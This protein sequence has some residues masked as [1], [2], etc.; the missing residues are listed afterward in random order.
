[1]KFKKFKL[2]TTL[3]GLYGKDNYHSHI[4]VGKEYWYWFGEETKVWSVTHKHWNKIVVTYIRSGCM[5]YKVPDVPEIS[6][7]YC[8]LSC[9]MTSQFEVTELDPIKE[10]LFDD[11]EK[12]KKLYYFKGY[13]TVIHNW[14]N[15]KEIEIS[16]DGELYTASSALS[17]WNQMSEEE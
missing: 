16:S 2:S 15:E 10:R 3:S 17:V 5:F 13:R 12:A 7:D 4:E 6:E 9:Y 14:P 8:P 11:V 1:M